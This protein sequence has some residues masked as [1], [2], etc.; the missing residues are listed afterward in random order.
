M[1]LNEAQKVELN[2][3]VFIGQLTLGV[4]MYRDA[5]QRL[6]TDQ[7]VAEKKHQD[8][9]GARIRGARPAQDY[10]QLSDI[11][12]SP[13][14]EGSGFRAGNWV[15]AACVVCRKNFERLG[16]LLSIDGDQDI[17]VLNIIALNSLGTLKTQLTQ[18]CRKEYPPFPRGDFGHATL[19]AK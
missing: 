12:V 9:K 13:A 2:A 15:E 7:R 16:K 11:H 4:N 14:P 18:T 17:A 10:F 19:G 1:I 8:D 5:A 6:S 3:G